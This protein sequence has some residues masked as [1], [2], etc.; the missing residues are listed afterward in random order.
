[1][2]KFVDVVSAIRTYRARNGGSRSDSAIL[3]HSTGDTTI[4]SASDEM[5]ERALEGQSNKADS[6][7]GRN[8][9]PK[10]INELDHRAIWSRYNN[11]PR[12]GE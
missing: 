10:T 6:A 11:P 5:I 3:S 2:P 4:D 12:Q 1:M 8:P 9:R 7:F